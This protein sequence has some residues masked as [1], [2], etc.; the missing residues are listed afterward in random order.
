[1]AAPVLVP[2]VVHTAAAV[3][4][5]DVRQFHEGDAWDASSPN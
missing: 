4:L 5:P 3:T 1:V 2:T